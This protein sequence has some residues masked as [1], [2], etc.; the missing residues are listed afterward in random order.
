MED[1]VRRIRVTEIVVARG[2][3]VYQAF[4]LNARN[5]TSLGKGLARAQAKV[6]ALME[7]LEGF[8]AE[9]IRLTVVR[10]TV[11]QSRYLGSYRAI[12]M[13]DRLRATKGET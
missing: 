9:E 8:H 12:S 11:R 13:C 2:I 1:D 10:D 5:V 6:S 3:P 7:S 4:R